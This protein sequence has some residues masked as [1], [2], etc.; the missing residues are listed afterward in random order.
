MTENFIVVISGKTFHQK[1]HLLQYSERKMPT[2]YNRRVCV[3][4]RKWSLIVSHFNTITMLYK[5]KSAEKKLQ[6]FF[7]C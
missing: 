6:F 2:L 7:S 4:V 3:R 5:L 1:H